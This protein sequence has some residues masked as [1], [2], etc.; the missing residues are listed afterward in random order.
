MLAS[1]ML[2]AAVVGA[3]AQDLDDLGL[4]LQCGT[5][6]VS[7][8]ACCRAAWQARRTADPDAKEILNGYLRRNCQGPGRRK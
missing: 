4:I 2:L 5:A 3:P 8:R 1:A 7:T 6:E